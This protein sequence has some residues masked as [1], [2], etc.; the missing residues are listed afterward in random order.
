MEDTQNFHST[1][2]HSIGQDM[3]EPCYDKFASP[4]DSTRSPHLGVIREH[5]G[6]VAH[7]HHKFRRYAWAILGNVGSLVVQVLKGA[8]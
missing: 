6:A 8:T 3:G 5:C 1:A 4:G 2:A 7:M